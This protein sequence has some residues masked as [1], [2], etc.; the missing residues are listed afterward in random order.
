M[1]QFQDGGVKQIVAS[2]FYCLQRRHT[3]LAMRTAE[4][5]IGDGVLWTRNKTTRFV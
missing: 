4:E 2:P 5:N 1:P 3:L